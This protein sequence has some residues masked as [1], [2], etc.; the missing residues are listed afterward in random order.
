ME[1]DNKIHVSMP[2]NKHPYFSFIKATPVAYGSSRL[3]V[4]A[5]L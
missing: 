1:M 5:E 2:V 3:G 4:E